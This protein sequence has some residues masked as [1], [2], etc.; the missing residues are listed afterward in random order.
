MITDWHMISCKHC[1]RHCNVKMAR[2]FFS[3]WK[4]ILLGLLPT[5]PLFIVC[6]CILSAG[7]YSDVFQ[8]PD[9]VYD[10]SLLFV[11]VEAELSI[12][13]VV[14]C[15]LVSQLVMVWVLSFCRDL[16][17]VSVRHCTRLFRQL[18]T[19]KSKSLTV[20]KMWSVLARFAPQWRCC[21][22]HWRC[23][24]FSVCF[25]CQFGCMSLSVHLSLLLCPLGFVSLGPFHCA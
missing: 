19:V 25:F 9:S 18:K 14:V 10:K 7:T 2:V 15:A 3:T 12:D 4:L 23:F 16:T 22:L 21:S 20:V 5:L 8:M 17:S 24:A 6:L 1:I 11:L 13:K